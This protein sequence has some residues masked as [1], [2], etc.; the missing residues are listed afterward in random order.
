MIEQAADA[1]W[2]DT[3]RGKHMPSEWLGKLSLPDAYAVQLAVLK[4][5]IAEGETHAGW[6][7]G[8]TAAALR[9]RLGVAEPVFGYLTG[10]G[11]ATSGDAFAYGT[12]IKPAI[13]PE[14][15]LTLGDTLRGDALTLADAA[16]AV[17]TVQ[18]ALEL[19]EG[20]ADFQNQMPL[21]V[22]DNVQHARWVLGKPVAFDASV[23]LDAVRT[24]L[25][26]N[27]SLEA[28]AT[29][30]TVYGSPLASLVWLAGA[31]HRHGLAL[32]PGMKV[33]TGSFTPTG[34]PLSAGDTV[35]ARFEHFGEVT[36]S[37]PAGAN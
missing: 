16:R 15:C 11:S 4:R 28:S 14:L 2:H 20:R 24:E 10:E 9:D 17:A 32:E 3:K 35:R 31:L 5:R 6:K 26:I 23:A 7:V 12:F 27:Q 1:I 29:G 34:L 36:A 8:L 25:C 19:V 13:E 37:F 30:A 22:A 18:P 33:M 21:S